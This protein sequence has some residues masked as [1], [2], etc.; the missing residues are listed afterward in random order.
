MPEP[1]PQDAETITHRLVLPRD[2]NHHG[3]LYAGTLLSLALEAGYS[4]A[5][6]AAGLSANLV[7]KRVLD[8]RCYAPVPVGH[9][10][11]IRGRQIHRGS[12]QIVVALWGT[13][14][15]RSRMP[16]MDGLMQFVHVGEDGR[17][18]PLDEA[19]D[20]TPPHLDAPWSML[21]DR[22][23]KLLRIRQ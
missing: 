8:L 2:A 5:Y 23:R 12:A 14:L 18:E 11:Q 1:R 15:G 20:E 4:T 22:T 21:Q 13:P 3:T 19:P 16:W 17:P 10:V 6:H 9:V 7:L